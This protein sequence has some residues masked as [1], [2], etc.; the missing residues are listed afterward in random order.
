MERRTIKLFEIAHVNANYMITIDE[1]REFL[2][3]QRDDLE[4]KMMGIDT[5][6]EKIQNKLA[7]I[8]VK[9][10]EKRLR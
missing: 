8:E 10:V 2:H 9:R 7:E 4:G 5:N 3:L 6:Q 1:D